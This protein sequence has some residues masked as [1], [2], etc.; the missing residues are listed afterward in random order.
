MTDIYLPPAFYYPKALTNGARVLPPP[1]LR[2]APANARQRFPSG[3][4]RP[5]TATSDRLGPSD[6]HD[7][8]T[9]EAGPPSARP[10]TSSMRQNTLSF[11]YGYHTLPATLPITQSHPFSGPTSALQ[12]PVTPEP[13]AFD[14]DMKLLKKKGQTID[15]ID[16]A[17]RKLGL[18][19]LFSILVLAPR[20]IRLTQE[21]VAPP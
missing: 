2:P 6:R 20:T 3:S 5:S 11:L 4:E 7:Q 13:N 16:K 8:N 18:Y 14:R 9:N 15:L 19:P 10:N 12:S 21:G 17:G 1:P